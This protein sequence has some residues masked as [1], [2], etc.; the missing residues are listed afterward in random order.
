[1][2]FQNFA[3]LAIKGKRLDRA[4]CRRVLGCPDD[5]IISLIDAAYQ[6]RHKYFGNR[7]Y[8]H[9]L[10]NAKSGLCSEDCHYCSQSRIADSGIKTYPLVSKEKLLTEAREAMETKANRF[11]M[12]LSGKSPSEKELQRLCDIIRSLKQETGLSLCASLGFL[13]QGQA[14]QLKAAGLDRVNH[15]LNTSERFYSRICTTHSFQDRV[16]TIANCRAAGLEICS[17]GII[18][19]GETDEDIIDLLYALRDIKPQAVPINFLIPVKGTPFED[20]ATDLNPR[21]C[22]KALCLARF[23]N[24]QSEVRAAGGREY[25]LRSLQ[26]LA[27][28]AVDSIFVA[29]YLTTGGQSVKDAFNMIADLGFEATIEGA[30]IDRFKVLAKN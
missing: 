16:G 30:D 3:D 15:N 24:P 6:V 18:G 26:P 29:G 2:S 20:R 7:V 12:A 22:L 28:Y 13:N 21:R 19:Q 11:C 5:E 8:I 23:L 25:H 9:M 4:Q 1:M 14:A 17:G 10:S 27:L